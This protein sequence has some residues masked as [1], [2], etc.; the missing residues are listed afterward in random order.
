MR[1]I[2]DVFEGFPRC[3]RKDQ[4]KEG[5]GWHDR[6]G[7]R[8]LRALQ[9]QA[10]IWNMEMLQE[11]Q[12]GFGKG[13]FWK[14]G[15]SRKVLVLEILKRFEIPQILEKPQTLENKGESDRCLEILE[16]SKILALLEIPPVKRPLS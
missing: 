3:F 7:H 1:K 15:L 12:I 16:N 5:Q 2:L 9:P 14:R 10:Q 6:L 8:W 13:V 4:G 11:S